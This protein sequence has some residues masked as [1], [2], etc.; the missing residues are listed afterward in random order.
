MKKI[1]ANPIIAHCID[2]VT[3]RILAYRVNT[4]RVQTSSIATDDRYTQMMDPMLHIGD[5]EVPLP[6]TDTLYIPTAS[7][8]GTN[9]FGDC[10]MNSL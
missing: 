8:S 3:K 4:N 5:S 1:R 10:E 9:V 2:V 6:T 7:G